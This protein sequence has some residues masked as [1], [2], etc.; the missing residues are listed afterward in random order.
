MRKI[1]LLLVLFAAGCM[2]ADEPS[3]E[4]GGKADTV[5]VLDTVIMVQAKGHPDSLY[6]VWRGTYIGTYSTLSGIQRLATAIMLSIAP[7]KDEMDSLVCDCFAHFAITQVNEDG[8]T[9]KD[10]GDL[11][12]FKNGIIRASISIAE[13]DLAASLSGDSITIQQIG[14]GFLRTEGG[15]SMER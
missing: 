15:V 7:A 12:Y 11:H 14:K 1:V 5:R 3:C 9:L 10:E 8:L 13:F 4:D 6:G 2:T